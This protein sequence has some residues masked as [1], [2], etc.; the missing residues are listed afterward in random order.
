MF[1]VLLPH[2]S[3]HKTALK[4]IVPLAKRKTKNSNDQNPSH[5]GSVK[6]K[7]KKGRL[8]ARILRPWSLKDSSEWLHKVP[9]ARDPKDEEEER[10]E[11]RCGTKIHRDRFLGLRPPP[12]PNLLSPRLILL[13]LSLSFFSIPRSGPAAVMPGCENRHPLTS[14]PRVF[15]LLSLSNAFDR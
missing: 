6:K 3:Q 9:S 5:S 14:P 8:V 11:G 2:K 15:S 4:N 13:K 1:P 7:R 12:S 10:A